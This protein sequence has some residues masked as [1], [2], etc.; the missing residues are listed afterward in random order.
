M[1]NL[2]GRIGEDVQEYS[3]SFIKIRESLNI[4][5]CLSKEFV[6]LLD[7]TSNEDIDPD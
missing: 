5:R 4:V 2:S 7:Y 3:S 6:A 1:Q